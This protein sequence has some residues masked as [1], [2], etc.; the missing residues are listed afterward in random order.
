MR[1][2]PAFSFGKA[3]ATATPLRGRVKD[4]VPTVPALLSTFAKV[5]IHRRRPLTQDERAWLSTWFSK[6][7]YF[8]SHRRLSRGVAKKLCLE[9]DAEWGHVTDD[10]PGMPVHDVRVV[11]LD[12]DGLNKPHPSVSEYSVVNPTPVFGRQ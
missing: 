4:R 2:Q 9:M 6:T 3:I 1:V 11:K 7:Q 12:R 8:K 10:G 5:G